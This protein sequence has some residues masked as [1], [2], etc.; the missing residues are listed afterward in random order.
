M[1]SAG[2]AMR[3]SLEILQPLI[4][5]PNSFDFYA[6]L[7]RLECAAPHKP[8][9]GQ[10]RR[11]QDEIA[12][13]GQKPSL[14]FEAAAVTAV[15]DSLSIP[16]LYISFFGLLGPN[17]PLPLHLTE[18]AIDRIQ[19]RKDKT[20]ARFLD[21]FHH[22]LISLFYRSWAV[23]QPS[24]S[25]D[26]PDSDR[27]ANYLNSLMGL[28]MNSF[29]QRDAISDCSKLHYVGY[30]SGLTHHAQGLAAFLTNFFKLSIRIEQFIGEWLTLPLESRW[31]LRN[32][33]DGEKLG[34]ATVL[35]SRI[36]SRQHKFRIVIGPLNFKEFKTFLPG[37]RGL[38]RLTAWVSNYIGFEY[39][40]EVC[41][42]LKSHEVPALKLGLAAQLGWTT[43]LNQPAASHC[44]KQL[45]LYLSN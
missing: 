28:G 17:G 40:W 33:P 12:Y 13:F 18:Y 36:W 32:A 21:I 43:W 26:R 10:A 3:N 24:V 2:R 15:Q 39:A 37:A 4:A 14:S 8:R 30:L 29:R 7:R 22:R 27:F 1:A 38:K 45:L 42:T 41:L 20:L 35:G 16:K 44:D 23:A 31:V 34:V 25:F 6:A 5:A 19:I 11:I 9:V